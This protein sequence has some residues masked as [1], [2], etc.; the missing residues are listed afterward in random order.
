M[1]YYNV[2]LYVK[3]A[4]LGEEMCFHICWQHLF[5]RATD[6]LR[7]EDENYAHVYLCH[8]HFQFTIKIASVWTLRSSYNLLGRHRMLWNSS[9]LC[10]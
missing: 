3:T 2:W 9:P 10:K 1:S 5:Q 8:I 6:F 4:C 7:S